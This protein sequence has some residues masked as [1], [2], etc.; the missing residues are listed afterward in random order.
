MTKLLFASD[1]FKG[2]LSSQETARILTEELA[3][4]SPRSTCTALAVGD[5]GEGTAAALVDGVGGDFMGVDVHD[6]LGRPLKTSYARLADGRAVIEMA[7]ASGLSLLKRSELDPY[8]ATSYGTGELIRAALEAG[9]DDVLICVGGTATNDGGMGAMRAL[10]VRFLDENDV[11]L[12]GCGADLVRVHSIDASGLDPK[13]KAATFHVLCDVASPLIGPKGATT[14]FGPQKGADE[15]AVEELE[16]G[17]RSYA[18]VLSQ[19]A[20]RDITHLPGGGAAGGMG[21]ACQVLLDAVYERGGDYVLDLLG[22]DKLLRDVDLVVT[23]EGH[24]DAQTAE[25]K[26]V[27]SVARRAFEHG[28]S[29]VAVVGAADD[30][31]LD[32]LDALHLQVVVSCSPSPQTETEMKEGAAT[33]YRQTVRS[34]FQVFMLGYNAGRMAAAIE[35]DF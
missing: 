18:Q 19:V 23:G 7:A 11:E 27:S 21:V 6:P 2:T 3:E 9:A 5:G 24:L 25:G 31:S 32:V 15:K 12:E 1:S 34:F 14:I 30:V 17:M 20:G 8:A 35:G 16:A 33:A 26:V 22:F 13:A 10:G 29:C 4:V 28:V